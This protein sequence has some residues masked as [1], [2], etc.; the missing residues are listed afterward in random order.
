MYLFLQFFLNLNLVHVSY[1]Y[2]MYYFPV[3][4]ASLLGSSA[5]LRKAIICFVMSVSSSVRMEQI[6][7]HWKDFNE[8]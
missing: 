8:I 5:K 7:S 3:H 6:V 4:R 2:R 1:P